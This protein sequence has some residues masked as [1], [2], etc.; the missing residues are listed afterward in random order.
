MSDKNLARRA[1]LSVAFDGVDISND[2]SRF[3]LSLTYTDNE[4]DETDDLQI[5][6]QDRG[7]IW[8]KKWLNLAINAAAGFKTTVKTRAYVVTAAAGVAVR[9][10]P[11]SEYKKLGALA[12]NA[13]VQVSSVSGGW[14]KCVWSGQTAYVTADGIRVV[15]ASSSAPLA[16]GDEVVATGN[17]QYTSY[18]EGTPGAKVTNYAGTVTRINRSA[19]YPIHVG[20]LGWFAESQVKK[21]GIDAAAETV[22]S[23]GKGMRISAAITSRNAKSDGKDR[24]L[25]CGSFELDG[26][27]C[28]GPPA[29]ITIKATSLPYS[30]TLRQTEKSR[31]WESYSLSKI[32]KELAGNNGMSAM[33]TA[34]ADPSYKRIEQYRMSDIAFLQKLCRDAGIALKVTNNIIVVF[35]GDA[36]GTGADVLTIREGKN[37]GYSNYKLST[38]QSKTYTSCRVACTTASGTVI[39][40]VAY[41]ED[42][43]EKSESNQ[44]LEIRQMVGSIAEAKKLAEAYLK[45]YNKYEKVCTFTLPG[46]ASLLAGKTVSLSGFGAF[47]GKYVI[48]K[49]QHSVSTRGYTTTVTLRNVIK[50]KQE[51]KPAAAAAPTAAEIDRV[52]WEVIRGSWGNG[53]DRKKRLKA[54]GYDPAV[55]QKRVNELLK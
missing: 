9:S 16:V 3:L 26:V 54:A 31:S 1:A 52:A 36:K 35:D 12:Y 20:Y 55:I 8:R 30:S 33:Y 28:S 42:Y 21:A 45:L 49:A 32:V 19:P 7:G 13:T 15:S 44:Q 5:T 46:D 39:S 37:G 23:V 29:V 24:V 41:V 2:M 43:K 17:P 50:T 14:A 48:A 22:G 4:E 11:G 25:D 51:A 27:Q 53:D 40:A 47:D 38:K 6:L 10:G 18:G 34:A